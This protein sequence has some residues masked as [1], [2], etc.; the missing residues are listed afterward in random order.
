MG[1]NRIGP[2]T[3]DNLWRHA[4]AGSRNT[5]AGIGRAVR[6]LHRGLFLPGNCCCVSPAAAIFGDRLSCAR[7]SKRGASCLRSSSPFSFYRRSLSTRSW[8]A[9]ILAGGYGTC[10]LSVL[11]PNGSVRQSPKLSRPFGKPTTY[12]SFWL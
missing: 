6:Y 11:A 9:R 7:P 12:G 1:R 3:L 10:W 2:P 4:D 8:A 5:H